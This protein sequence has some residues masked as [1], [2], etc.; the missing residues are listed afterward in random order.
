MGID[1]VCQALVGKVV[2]AG[3]EKITVECNGKTRE[4][5]SNLVNVKEGDNVLFSLDIA[6]EKIDEEEAKIIRGEM[7]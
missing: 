1:N 4:L 5:R 2:K 7:E 3:G 6:I